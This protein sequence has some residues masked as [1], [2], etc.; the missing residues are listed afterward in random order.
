MRLLPDYCKSI[1]AG[2]PKT[3]GLT[4]QLTGA[5]QESVIITASS[6]PPKSGPGLNLAVDHMT[7]CAII[8]CHPLKPRQTHTVH[9]H[10]T[11]T[12]ADFGM[13]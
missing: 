4:I 3:F 10:S 13:V 12:V 6:L 8:D 7:S 9:T 11:W 2:Y 1:L 5:G